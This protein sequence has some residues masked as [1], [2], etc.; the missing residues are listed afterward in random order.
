[1]KSFDAISG[2]YKPPMEPPNDEAETST[3]QKPS[4][5][6]GKPVQKKSMVGAME[7]D[8]EELDIVPDQS[9]WL[10]PAKAPAAAATT[11]RSRVPSNTSSL[12]PKKAA[13]P[14]HAMNKEALSNDWN[15]DR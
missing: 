5:H 6:L 15:I 12:S 2:P 14:T 1:M 11:Q 10:K 13:S 4:K 8:A 7:D 3:E 9:K